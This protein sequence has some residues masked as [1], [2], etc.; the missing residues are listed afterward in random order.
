M[1]WLQPTTVDLSLTARFGQQTL[2]QTS[3]YYINSIQKTVNDVIDMFTSEDMENT[4]IYIIKK[5]MYL[6]LV[7]KFQYFAW[8][9]PLQGILCEEVWYGLFK[10]GFIR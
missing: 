3:I 2:Q 4:R 8:P 9:W 6:A 7:P 1:S 10:N 5:T